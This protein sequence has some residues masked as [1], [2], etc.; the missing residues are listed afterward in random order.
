M[1]VGVAVARAAVAEWIGNEWSD[2]DEWS[3]V[4]VVDKEFPCVN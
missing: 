1:V 3:E 4:A 2:G